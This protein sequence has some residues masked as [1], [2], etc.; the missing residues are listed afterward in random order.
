MKLIMKSSMT[1]LI[2]NFVILFWSFYSAVWLEN[3]SIFSENGLLENFQALTLFITLF[4]FLVPMFNRR[5][6]DRLLA[7]F[8]SILTLGF[9]L[10]ELDVETF[11]LPEIF[12]I[13]GSGQGRDLLLSFGILSTIG[14][15]LLKFRYYLDLAICFLKS[16]SGFAAFSSGIFLYIGDFF[17]NL[18]IPYNVLYEESFELMGYSILLLAA[19]RLARR[20]IKTSRF[21][22]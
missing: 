2:L 11:D 10:R 14:F 3:R 4:F 22:Y 8:F 20:E 12:I 7:V 13:L 17:E 19:S 6:S 9:V 15:A 5:R 1:A 16:R 18:Q 21:M